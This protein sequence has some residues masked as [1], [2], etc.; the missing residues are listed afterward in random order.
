MQT[1]LKFRACTLQELEQ[2]RNNRRE[3]YFYQPMEG[4]TEGIVGVDT[5]PRGDILT[6]CITANKAYQW[7]FR[8][9]R[10]DAA[11]LF[12]YDPAVGD[13]HAVAIT[14]ADRIDI[15]EHGRDNFELFSDFW[16]Y[17][18]HEDLLLSLEPMFYMTEV[19]G[20]PQIASGYEWHEHF[21]GESMKNPGGR[22]YLTLDHLLGLYYN[23]LCRRDK[24]DAEEEE[25]NTLYDALNERFDDVKENKKTALTT[26][27]LVF[28]CFE[29]KKLLEDPSITIRQHL[30]F[31]TKIKDLIP[32]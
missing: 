25:F 2:A 20:I 15:Y 13:S 12:T 23:N 29:F 31:A 19:H 8:S 4:L 3:K 7:I 32:Q 21:S 5:T 24:T 1:N 30:D 6:F 10:G 26:S 27:D 11:D 14:S 22:L 16:M 9:G 28:A 17:E 18:P